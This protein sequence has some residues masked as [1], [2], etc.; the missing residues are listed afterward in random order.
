MEVRSQ[1]D[2]EY[3]GK[4]SR[5]SSRDVV[6]DFI[7]NLDAIIG[8]LHRT[9]N[10]WTINDEVYLKGGRLFSALKCSGSNVGVAL[11]YV[12]IYIMDPRLLQEE[13]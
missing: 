9:L 13:I 11:V 2:S 3:F 7:L 1:L 10:M 5:R 12:I 6:P 8:M 4:P